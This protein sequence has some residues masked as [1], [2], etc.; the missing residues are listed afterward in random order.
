MKL[1]LRPIIVAPSLEDNPTTAWSNADGCLRIVPPYPSTYHGAVFGG[2]FVRTRCSLCRAILIGLLS[3]AGGPP[4][5][6]GAEPGAAPA[7][8]VAVT[9]ATL[10]EELATARKLLSERRDAASEQMREI[11]A[12]LKSLQD[13]QAGAPPTP[14]EKQRADELEARR[15]A[16]QDELAFLESAA[17]ARQSALESLQTRERIE[18]ETRLLEQRSADRP[19][20]YGPAQVASLKADIEAARSLLLTIQQNQQSRQTQVADLNRRIERADPNQNVAVLQAQRAALEAQLASSRE[21]IRTW[22][23]RIALA[24]KKLSLASPATAATLK[25]Q[26]TTTSAP[27]NEARDAENK[28]KIAEL[29]AEEA[30]GER[31]K[32]RQRLD[33]IYRKLFEEAEAGSNTAGLEDDRDYWERKLSYESRRLRQA[34][35]A[36]RIAAEKRQIAQLQSRID[37]ASQQTENLYKTRA[38]MTPEEREELQQEFR[39]KAVEARQSAQEVLRRAQQERPTADLWDKFIKSVDALEEALRER[40][41]QEYNLLHYQRMRTL[42]DAERQQITSLQDSTDV[43]SLAL[44]RQAEKY[45]QLAQL[46]DACAEILVPTQPGFLERNRRIINSIWIVLTAVAA[47]YA[48]RLVAWLALR[49]TRAA[50]VR[51]PGRFSVKRIETLLSFFTSITK[52]FIWIFAIVL[53]LNEFKIDPAQSTAYIG[54]V[55]ILL[56][57]MFQQIVIDFVKGFDIISGRHYNVGDFVELDGKTGHV[58][59]FSVKHTR[60]RTPSGQEYNLPNSKCIPSRRFPDGYVDN[61]VDVPVRSTADVQRARRAIAPVCRLLSRRVEQVKEEPV[62]VDQFPGTRPNSLILRY[63]VRILPAS[64]WVITEQFIPDVKASLA[65]EGIELD[66]EPGFFFINR[67]QV[68]RQLFARELSEEQILKE[69]KDQQ[70]PTAERGTE[71]AEDTGHLQKV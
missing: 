54:I 30:R 7:G 19:L 28:Q 13:Q 47:G 23:A 52:V 35:T 40:V 59:D 1:G 62:F 64:E 31:T 43:I 26:P 6:Q 11:Q 2:E 33:A 38:R 37:A 44:S 16:L 8:P 69:A 49:L 71:P 32:A 4:G 48:L 56:A 51:M 15:T 14:E 58:I 50:A 66:D 42:L 67:I 12:A 41:K 27:A 24:R 63:R 5:A 34:D 17:S 61:Y 60:I 39:Q 55:T 57:A 21:S 46:Y 25:T 3:A 65:A 10:Q 18:Q 70:R 9:A 53:V 68:F 22:E 45:Q 29:L 36:K 20:T